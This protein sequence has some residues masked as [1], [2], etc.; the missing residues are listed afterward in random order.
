MHIF[1]YLTVF[2]LSNRDYLYKYTHK[3]KSFFYHQLKERN[4]VKSRS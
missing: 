4:I 3:S 2:E 1:L